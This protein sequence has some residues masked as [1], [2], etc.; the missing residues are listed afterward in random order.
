MKRTAKRQEN[1]NVVQRRY[2]LLYI[3]SKKKPYIIYRSAEYW[4]A[5]SFSVRG[6]TTHKQQTYKDDTL[7]DGRG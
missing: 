1:F 6:D 4:P 2:S 3:C 7:M 5:L